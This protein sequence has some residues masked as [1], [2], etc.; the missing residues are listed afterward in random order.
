MAD[1]IDAESILTV[2]LLNFIFPHLQQG[3]LPVQN[4]SIYYI[5]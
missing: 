2:N 5:A 3:R 1:P 4:N